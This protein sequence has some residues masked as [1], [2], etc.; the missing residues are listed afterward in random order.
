ADRTVPENYGVTRA[1]I[2][3][4]LRHRERSPQAIL[5]SLTETYR[6]RHGKQ[7]WIEK[8]PTHL[9]HLRAVRRHYPDAPTIRILRD[10][11]ACPLPM[12]KGPW[13]PPSSASAI[14]EWQRFDQPS[15][16]FFETD[17]NTL[18]LLFED[19]VR[20]PEGQLRQVC[21]FIGEEFE[22]GMLDTSRSIRHV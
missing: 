21:Y 1:E 7:R 2:L 10:P 4:F 19:L 6:I 20:D 16:A 8:T 5:E 18:P 9:A 22:P 14:L 3:G 15:A 12:P 17:R 13:P 11:R